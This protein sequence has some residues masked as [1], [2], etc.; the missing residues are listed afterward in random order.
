MPIQVGDRIPDV[1]LT[2][3]GPAGPVQMTTQDVFSGKKVVLFAVT[4]AFTALC[5]RHH[6]PGYLAQHDALKAKG[7]DTIACVAVNDVEVM[8]AWAEANQV[9]DRILMIADGNADFARALGL[10]VDLSRFGLGTRSHRY[11]M[12]VD[13]G[14]VRS[15][16]I[17]EGGKLKVAAADATLCKV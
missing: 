15:L 7:V 16:D 14:V 11:A 12:V 6:L 2:A 9:G 3:V 13:G 5:H 4:G 17:D 10:D 8:T 1:T